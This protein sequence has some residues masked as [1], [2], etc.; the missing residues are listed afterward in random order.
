MFPWVRR[1]RVGSN[2]EPGRTP[3]AAEGPTRYDAT[4]QQVRFQALP[5]LA[6]KTETSYRLKVQGTA[7][8]DLRIRAQLRSD[9][10]TTPITKEESTR[11]YADQ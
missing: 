9:D 2:Q 1:T 10:V 6:P 5:R 8:G 11:V 4:A 7:P 3:A